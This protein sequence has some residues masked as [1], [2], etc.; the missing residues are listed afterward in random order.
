VKRVSLVTVAPV[1]TP[2]HLL[3]SQL[4]APPN[5]CTSTYLRTLADDRGG[6][7]GTTCS[8]PGE[9]GAKGGGRLGSRVHPQASLSTEYSVCG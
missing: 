4:A 7:G 3:P 1:P 5:G 9:E 6:K 2:P 8:V